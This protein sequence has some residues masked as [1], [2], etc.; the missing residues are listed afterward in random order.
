MLSA[1]LE[2][3]KIDNKN[4]FFQANLQKCA[5]ILNAS[6]VNEFSLSGKFTKKYTIKIF[7]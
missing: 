5:R 6:I 3:N 2:N 4:I 7:I 1:L